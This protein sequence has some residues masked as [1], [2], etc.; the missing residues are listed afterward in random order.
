MNFTPEKP[1]LL[2]NQANKTSTSSAI[3]NKVV[4]QHHY[5]FVDSSQKNI[6]TYTAKIIINNVYLQV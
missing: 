4:I 5:M 6:F 1:K 2:Q 3:T